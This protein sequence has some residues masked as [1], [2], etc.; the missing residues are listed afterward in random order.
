MHSSSMKRFEVWYV[1][2]EYAP[3]RCAARTFRF[4]SRPQAKAY[5]RNCSLGS[6]SQRCAG[7]SMKYTLIRSR[8]YTSVENVNVIGSGR[9][10]FVLR[11]PKYSRIRRVKTQQR[12]PSRRRYAA[13]NASPH[14]EKPAARHQTRPAAAR[15]RTTAFNTQTHTWYSDKTKDHITQQRA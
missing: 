1:T 11:L 10:V 8:R 9:Q 7:K 2:V 14:A 5:K 4:F 6:P 13:L 12:R 15:S 3:Q